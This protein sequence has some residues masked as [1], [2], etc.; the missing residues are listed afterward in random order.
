[1]D[2]VVELQ[3]IVVAV[4]RLCNNTYESVP[5]WKQQLIGFFDSPGSGNRQRLTAEENRQKWLA[6]NR[7]LNGPLLPQDQLTVDWT[8]TRQVAVTA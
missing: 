6:V 1:M 7:K 8:D 3:L 2:H 5:N 4:N